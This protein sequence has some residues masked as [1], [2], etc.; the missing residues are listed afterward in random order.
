MSKTKRTWPLFVLAGSSFLPGLGFFFGVAAAVWGLI[1]DRS[2]AM[3]A[4][5]IGAGGALLNLI[6]VVLLMWHFEQDP[7]FVSADQQGTRS[8]LAQ[9]VRA[10]EGHRREKGRYPEEL[11]VFTKPPYS[12]R[13]IN[14][15]DFSAGIIR[16]P[17]DYHYELASD[18]QTYTLFAV[19]IDG[20]PGTAD[21]L[22][23]D[24]PDSAARHSGYRGPR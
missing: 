6:G 17:R 19:G 24:L 18:G 22:Y 3:L 4:A 5:A 2:R 13:L 16:W 8:D 1:S 20:Q 21:D 9:V 15:Q 11:T 10:L 7:A 12:L 14:I 23:P